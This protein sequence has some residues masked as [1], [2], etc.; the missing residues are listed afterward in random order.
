MHSLIH[1]GARS[2]LALVLSLWAAAAWAISPY[3]VGDKLA[4]G[5]I[6]D[7]VAQAT[8]KLEAG[9]FTVV[10]HYSPK[11][12]EHHAVVIAT[13]AGMLDSIRKLGGSTIVGAG[14][15]VGVKSDG[16]LTYMNPEYWYR[17]YFRKQ[18]TQAQSTV[19]ALAAKLGK[20]LGAHGN[21]GGEED[22]SDLANY[23]Y[24]VGMERFDDEKNLL[25]KSTTFDDAVKT[26]QDNLAKGVGHTAKVYEII[27]PEKQLA[28]FGVAMSDPNRGEGWWV[29]KIGPDNIAALPYEIYVVGNKA[30]ALYARYRIALSW[31]SLGMGPFMR[32]VEA[33]DAILYTLATVAGGS[34]G[35]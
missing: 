28:V 3:V 1:F 31:P 21:H 12:I 9:G 20:A 15:R 16:S 4:P 11:G 26:I 22:V 30:N 27:L 35:E 23:R 8:K 2:L 6:P 13:D 25:Y 14:L 7:L 10:G 32:I 18:Y 33:P 17:A 34:P 29:N 19:K 5:P 24:M